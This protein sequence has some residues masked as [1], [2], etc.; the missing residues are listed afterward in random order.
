MGIVTRKIGVFN[1]P[2][3]E[4]SFLAQSVR[5]LLLQGRGRGFESHKN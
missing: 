5:A 2:I 1:I 4:S 3:S